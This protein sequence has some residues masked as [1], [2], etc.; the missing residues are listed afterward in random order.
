[1]IFSNPLFDDCLDVDAEP[2]TIYE[3]TDKEIFVTGGFKEKK[4]SVYYGTKSC[5][6][7]SN[8][9]SY[10]G[11]ITDNEWEEWIDGKGER[12]DYS[13]PSHA[14]PYVKNGA[15]KKSFREDIESF[16][17]TLE[18]VTSLTVNDKTIDYKTE[19][20]ELVFSDSADSAVIV[21]IIRNTYGITSYPID[22]NTVLVEF[23]ELTKC[24]GVYE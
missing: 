15:W 19:N 23:E 3:I 21:E 9:A 13:E 17:S 6:Y 4:R 8:D 5:S 18:D 16:I 2:E 24:Y 10:H 7:K 11:G 22:K 12:I 14:K 20:L 1:M